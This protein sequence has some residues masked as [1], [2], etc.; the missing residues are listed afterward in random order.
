MKAPFALL[1]LEIDPLENDGHDEPID[2]QDVAM[3]TGMMFRIT[4]IHDAHRRDAD[5]ALRGAV[6]PRREDQRRRDAHEVEEALCGHVS[7]DMVPYS[8]ALLRTIA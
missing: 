7:V 3:T 5:A 6:G 2:A 8:Y 1:G 4:S